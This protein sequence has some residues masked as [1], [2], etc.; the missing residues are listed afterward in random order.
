MLVY[1]RGSC[2]SLL[3]RR[4]TVYDS[5]FVRYTGNTDAFDLWYMVE[6]QLLTFH[7]I[8]RPPCFPAVHESHIRL[9]DRVQM[10]RTRS[11]GAG[12]RLYKLWCQ[13]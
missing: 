9:Y 4:H 8:Q 13:Y 11:L 12:A 2:A 6:G 3:N 7:L 5:I 10:G 1:W